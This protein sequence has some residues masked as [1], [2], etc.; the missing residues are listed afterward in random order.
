MTQ[1]DRG[2]DRATHEAAEPHSTVQGVGLQSWR[3]K[4]LKIVRRGGGVGRGE[5]RERE[6]EAKQGGK[7]KRTEEGRMPAPSGPRCA[8]RFGASLYPQGPLWSAVAHPHSGVQPG[9]RQDGI[10]V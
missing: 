3:P 7:G 10:A 4:S 8:L 6:G 5:G 2:Y 9:C 1:G